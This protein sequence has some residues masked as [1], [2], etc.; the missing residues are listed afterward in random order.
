VARFGD[1]DTAIHVRIGGCSVHHESANGWSTVQTA[2]RLTQVATEWGQRCG[3]DAK[4][5]PIV[6]DVIGVGGGVV[7]ILAKGGWRVVGVNVALAA[8]DEGEYPNLRSALWF[9]LAEEAGRGNV[10]FARLP[11][12]VRTVLRLELT[13]PVYTVD[14]RGRRCVEPKDRT[15]ARLKRSPDSADAV[16]LAFAAV[17][18]QGERVAGRVQ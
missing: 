15:K 6:V 9:G 8:P 11:A 5:I 16:L 17:R 1:D 3:V 18:G 12:A 14:A 7:D 10:S 13:A 4:Q 2:D